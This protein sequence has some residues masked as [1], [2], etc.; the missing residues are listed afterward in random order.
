MN[1]DPCT[2]EEEQIA[3][4]IYEEFARDAVNPVSARIATSWVWSS[5]SCTNA[6]KLGSVVQSSTHP[7]EEL[8]Q[9]VHP[10]ALLVTIEVGSQQR[11]PRT[12]CQYR[13]VS[14]EQYLIHLRIPERLPSD[15][16]DAYVASDAETSLQVEKIMRMPMIASEVRYALACDPPDAPYRLL[17]YN[18]PTTEPSLDDAKRFQGPSLV[19]VWQHERTQ[20]GINLPSRLV[21][22]IRVEKIHGDVY[23][24]S[25]FAG[26]A[27][28]SSQQAFFYVAEPCKK[29]AANP[30]LS[31]ETRGESKTAHP[32]A[33]TETEL[34]T[35]SAFRHVDDYG[36]QYVGKLHPRLYVLD[37]QASDAASWR[38]YP[39]EIDDSAVPVPVAQMDVGDPQCRGDTLVWIVRQRRVDVPRGHIY[40]TN[41]PSFLVLAHLERRTSNGNNSGDRQSVL[42]ARVD[43]V[44]GSE[45]SQPAR[46]RTCPRFLQ[47]DLIIWVEAAC[48]APHCSAHWIVESK[49]IFGESA[50]RS[51]LMGECRYLLQVDGEA[52]PA[53]DEWPGGFYPLNPSRALL[54]GEDGLLGSEW[55]VLNAIVGSRA[56]P[57]LLNRRS[58][59]LVLL[60]EEAGAPA[61]MAQVLATRRCRVPRSRECG[62]QR[63]R[64]AIDLMVGTDMTLVNA[65]TVRLI[66]R[67]VSA[68]ASDVVENASIAC[69]GWRF[70]ANGRRYEATW[71]SFESR[72]GTISSMTGNRLQSVRLGIVSLSLSS[73][74]WLPESA[75]PADRFE[76]IVVAPDD[77]ILVDSQRGPPVVLFLHGGPHACFLANVWNPGA[78]LL[79][80]IGCVI[81]APNYRGS[82]GQGE[83]RLRSLLGRIGD[84]DVRE[85]GLALE[86]VLECEDFWSWFRP[87]SSDRGGDGQE[88]A[89]RGNQ[90]PW[91]PEWMSIDRDRIAVVGGSHG[92]FLAAH[93]SARYA[94]LVRAVVL[95]NPVIDISSMV[96]QTDITDW[97]YH[98]CGLEIAFSGETKI[99][100]PMNSC[101][102]T[103]TTAVCENIHR[104][105]LD[106]ELIRMRSCSP[107]TKADLVQAATLLQLGGHDQRVPSLQGFQ[108]ARAIRTKAN[109]LRI[110]FYPRSNHAI[111][112]SP[113]FD[114]A[115]I[116]CL[117]WL[118]KFLA[119]KLQ[120]SNG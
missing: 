65:P 91:R 74:G 4:K 48:D 26:C 67:L 30:S 53:A 16:G 84:Q 46:N 88:R 6:G 61:R 55:I 8:R 45:P 117:A 78:A 18:A 81:V 80:S 115:W 19:E 39:L 25:M 86:C 47:N 107:I 102:S 35:Y 114:D 28:S 108:W 93:L 2:R 15:S 83:T 118:F 24:D 13:Y 98:E 113:S 68:E 110:L 106:A 112:D 105:P 71:D 41:R 109:A 23:R 14:W 64:M 104:P 85:C 70:G 9:D 90:V 42:V 54:E 60:R 31:E 62:C 111:D 56:W 77:G 95:R 21:R 100:G 99:T 120:P 57:A 97:C 66:A 79:A 87:D 58:T 29:A 20:D 7:S 11:E 36:E 3:A 76:A 12:G 51:A 82:L 22:C 27:Y 1:R 116:Q 40:C 59:E 69:C 37:V 72:K 89:D 75:N 63:C 10:S 49:L 52:L 34:P 50:Q 17:F 101:D 33:A 38:V 94:K 103:N 96:S 32:D 73:G 43:F 92:G 44:Q 119:K 5:N